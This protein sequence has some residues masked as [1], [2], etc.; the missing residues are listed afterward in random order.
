[1]TF[2][3][4]R[5]RL[6][7]KPLGISLMIS[8]VIFLANPTFA[9]GTSPE[10]VDNAQTISPQEAKTLW[11]NGIKFIDTRKNSDWEAG[12]IPGALHINVKTEFNKEN[13]LRQVDLNE[14]VA[15]YC[16]AVKC[17]RAANAAKKLVEYGYQ[18]VYYYRLGFPSWKN[19]GYP[20]E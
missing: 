18:K 13:L 3:P 1:M 9:K 10:T 11:R 6:T 17:L 15:T 8:S 2:L 7:F 4:L 14:P 5:R 19:A 16:N 12:R 20:Y